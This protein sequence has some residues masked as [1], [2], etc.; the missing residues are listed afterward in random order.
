MEDVRGTKIVELELKGLTCTGC[1]SEV[2]AAL[3]NVGAKVIK[4]DLERAE[5]EIRGA[6]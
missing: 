2:K 5:I 4:I 1:I 6:R 3:E